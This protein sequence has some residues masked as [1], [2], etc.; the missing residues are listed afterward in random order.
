MKSKKLSMSIP[1]F[2]KATAVSVKKG[3]IGQ[4][5]NDHSVEDPERNF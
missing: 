4:D 2:M 5:E 1:N 3:R